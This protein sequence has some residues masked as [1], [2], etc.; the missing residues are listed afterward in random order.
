MATLV[1]HFGDREDRG[2]PCGICD[3]CSPE[4]R[5]A[6]RERALHQHEIQVASQILEIVRET[7]GISTGRLYTAACPNNA[8]DRRTFEELLR[9]MVRIRLVRLAQDA[10]EKRK[11]ELKQ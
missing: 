1:D 7:P 4:S 6:A 9:G 2:T 5:I 8:M 3:F 11:N 10:F